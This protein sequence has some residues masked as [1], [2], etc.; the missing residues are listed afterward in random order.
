MG[1]ND[2]VEVR[3]ERIAKV[4]EMIMAMLNAD[5]TGDGVFLDTA[6]AEIEYNTGLTEQRILKY[7]AN[8]EK[9]GRFIIDVKENKIKKAES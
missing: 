9:R 7:A 5:K 1:R 4:C 2:A 3:K 6:I 8:G